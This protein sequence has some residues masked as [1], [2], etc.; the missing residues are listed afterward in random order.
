MKHQVK[1]STYLGYCT[2]PIYFFINNNIHR[3]SFRQRAPNELLMLNKRL[4]KRLLSKL[5]LR[6][7][8]GLG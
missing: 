2:V 4:L 3:I 5:L 6:Y 1:S 8:L 7:M